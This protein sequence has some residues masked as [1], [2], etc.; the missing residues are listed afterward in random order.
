MYNLILDIVLVFLV[1]FIIA[2]CAEARQV[3]RSQRY[4]IL[5]SF[6]NPITIKGEIM[7][8]T[9]TT[10]QFA[11]GTLQTVDSKGRPVPVQSGSVLIESS[12][13]DVFIV[14]RDPANE[15]KFRVVAVGEGVAQLTYSADADRDDDEE[16]TITGSTTIDVILAEA[17]GFGGIVFGPPQEQDSDDDEDEDGGLVNPGPGLTNPA[18]GPGFGPSFGLPV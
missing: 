12:D 7:A 15:F 13:E 4:R 2:V 6:L 14:E 5:L 18:L 17:V 10:T 16:R 1:I 11:E 8:L 3:K 9:L